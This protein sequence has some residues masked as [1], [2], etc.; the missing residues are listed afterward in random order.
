MT[1]EDIYR[2]RGWLA[3]LSSKDR[4]AQLEKAGKA[5]AYDWPVWIA[6]DS[7]LP[8][9]DWLLW[10]LCFWRGFGKTRTGSETIRIW[11]KENATFNYALVARP[12]QH[13]PGMSWLNARAAC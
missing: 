2:V 1:L 6:R 12:R 8:P 4:R 10:L 7:Q 3:S 13:R 11:V 9:N 5:A